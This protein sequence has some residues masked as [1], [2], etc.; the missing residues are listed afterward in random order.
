MPFPEESFRFVSI[1]NPQEAQDASFQRSV[2]SHAV[3]QALQNKR[4]KEQLTSQ[5]F[6]TVLTKD[7]AVQTDARASSPALALRAFRLSNTNLPAEQLKLRA[8]LRDGESFLANLLPT[9]K[10]RYSYRIDK[11]KQAVEPVFSIGD[12]VD[13]QTFRSVFRT[14][15]ND[16]ALLNA[17]LLTATSAVAGG[18]VA[19]DSLRYQTETIK[20]LRQRI[21]DSDANSTL[22]TLG[23]IL[24][25]AGVEV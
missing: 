17:V 16:P 24:L 1:Q 10:E 2:R 7:R 15:L 25:L 20:T 4:K 9:P 8:L 19:G 11:A 13:F 22:S 21:S 14:S 3:K 6:R 12:D 23:A 18:T 5:N